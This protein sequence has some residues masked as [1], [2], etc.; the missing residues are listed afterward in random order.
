MAQ[1]STGDVRLNVSSFQPAIGVQISTGVDK[2]CVEVLAFQER[3][4]RG[5]HQIEEAP[6]SRASGQPVGASSC[7]VC[8]AL[9][10]AR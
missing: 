6:T 7:N 10:V 4:P 9:I 8:G 3:G 1:N 5:D 2:S